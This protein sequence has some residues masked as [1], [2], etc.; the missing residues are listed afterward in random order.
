MSELVQLQQRI[1]KAFQRIEAAANIPVL[2]ADLGN[3]P[4]HNLA[5]INL[6][7]IAQV[8]ELKQRRMRESEKLDIL[9]QRLKP[10]LAEVANA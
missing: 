1:E 5:E 9:I 7:L 10:F 3:D 4:T 2:P 6:E 8:D